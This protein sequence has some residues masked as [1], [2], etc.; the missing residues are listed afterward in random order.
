M[1][2]SGA[3][4]VQV[5]FREEIRACVEE[6]R[7]VET[8]PGGVYSAMR[9]MPRVPNNLLE[10]TAFHPLALAAALRSVLRGYGS[11]LAEAAGDQ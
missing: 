8:D 9:A 4:G 6:V 1:V 10:G 7:R 3:R 11:Y 2:F 5:E